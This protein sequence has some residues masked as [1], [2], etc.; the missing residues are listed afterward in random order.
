MAETTENLLTIRQIA[1]IAGVSKVTMYRFITDNSF[2][3]T[4][5]KRNAKM[6]D[7]TTVA[8]IIK[9]FNERS[10]S[11]VSETDETLEADKNNTIALDLLKDQVKE[12]QKQLSEKDEQIR[13]IH[14]LLDQQQQ[15]SLQDKNLIQE[16]KERISDLEGLIEAPQ[17]DNSEEK[18]NIAEATETPEMASES[19]KTKKWYHFW[20]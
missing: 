7:E 11:S 14:K 10:V 9:A 2:H 13:Q 19:V 6:Y 17:D 3:E 20:K 5:V 15:L 18:E 4:L 8:L 16:Q 1:D 12:Q